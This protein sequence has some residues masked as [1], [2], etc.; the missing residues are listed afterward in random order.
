MFEYVLHRNKKDLRE[1]KKKTK[2]S[3]RELHG[4]KVCQQC[5][6][7]PTHAKE[8]LQRRQTLQQQVLQSVKHVQL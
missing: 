8:R 4:E 5:L 7:Q 3:G 2:K 1:S 6:E